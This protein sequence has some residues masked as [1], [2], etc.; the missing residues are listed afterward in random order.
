MRFGA[1]RH[2]MASA[3]GARAKDIAPAGVA[4]VLAMLLTIAVV[5][6]TMAM[7]TAAAPGAATAAAAPG[8]TRIGVPIARTEAPAKIGHLTALSAEI[9]RPRLF[10]RMR[11]NAG[12]RE[13]EASF[14]SLGFRVVRFFQPLGIWV[15]EYVGPAAEAGDTVAAAAPS[16]FDLSLAE[17]A[18]RDAPGIG[19]VERAGIRSFDLVPDDPYYFPEDGSPGQY[20]PRAVGLEQAWDVTTGSSQVIAAFLDTG[21]GSG[22]PDFAGRIVSPYSAK[23]DSTLPA[24]WEDIEGHGSGTAGVAAALGDNGVGM[25]GAAWGVGIMP[26]HLSDTASSSIEDEIVGL[27]W[28]VEHGADVINLSLGSSEPDLAELD[29]IRYAI[30]SGVTVVASAGN[31]GAGAGIEYPAGYP[32]V[33]S[34][35]ATDRRNAVADYS[36]SG[37]GLDLVAP[38]SDI[39]TWS[40][41]NH[42]Y[43]P[44][45]ES[46]T[47]FAA[48]LVTGIV[49]LMLTEAPD[50][51]PPQVVTMLRETATDLGPAGRDESYGSGLVDADA[52]VAAAVEWELTTP[53]TEPP[54]VFRD[55][56]AGHPYAHAVDALSRTGV[57]E[58]YTNGR[59]GVNDPVTRQQ[60]AKMI[61][62]ALGQTATEDSVAPFEDV[63]ATSGGLY[64]DHYI[65]RAFELGITIGTSVHPPLFSPGEKIT[66]AQV[67]TMA[68][69][70]ATGVRPG[71][72]E[73]PPIGFLPSFGRFS[74]AHDGAAAGAY[75]NGLLQGLQ[76]MG[77][78][79]DMWRPATRGEVA[80]ILAPLLS[81]R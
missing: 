76:G 7:T 36:N 79:Y 63:P 26:V 74:S 47:S 55:V 30:D 35:G 6:A 50:L 19:W 12:P 51:T 40:V 44:A 27:M 34:V 68:V 78:G 64:P 9:E 13:A 42:E 62:L 4:A 77:P 73:A 33:I 37:P 2:S 11:A 15:V 43:F 10:V 65:A 28:A 67:T 21:I 71:F 41:D 38:G 5:S 23:Y 52:A 45:L 60:F 32:G 17:R 81:A 1:R 72:L 54:R 80:Q 58:G 66:R 25:A 20:G 59:F 57:I 24:K 48:P 61:V 49:A 3:W 16:E 75:W 46:G 29:A 69:R 22:I 70:G 14:A 53:T 8:G 56:P 18:L 39:V 31:A